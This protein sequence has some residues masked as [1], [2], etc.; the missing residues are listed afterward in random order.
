MGM[1]RSV[2]LVGLSILSVQFGVALGARLAPE[3][4]TVGTVALRMGIAALVLLVLVRPRVRGLTRNDW[5]AVLALGAASVVTTTAYL[6]SATRIPLG[7]ATALEFLGPMMLAVLRA[8]SRSAMFWPLPA[9]AGVL[10]LTRPWDGELDPLGV[11]LALFAGVAWALYFLLTSTVARRFD[12]LQGIALYM[13]VAALLVAPVLPDAV[14][15]LTPHTLWLTVL[16]AILVP[17]I[18]YSLDILVLRRIPVALMGTLISMEPV[19]AVFIGYLVLGQRLGMVELLGILVICVA[20]AGALGTSR[21]AG[22]APVGADGGVVGL[23]VTPGDL[24]RG[25]DT[26][27]GAGVDALGVDRVAGDEPHPGSR[28]GQVDA[29]VVPGQA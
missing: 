29:V 20:C 26:H 16:M 28:V 1:S 21:A 5:L 9:A 6:W 8:P 4:G 27:A 12:G 17:L 24:H 23:P 2:A 7:T 13:P 11:G 18:P 25:G 22:T 3:L 14:A 10:A 15:R 19:V